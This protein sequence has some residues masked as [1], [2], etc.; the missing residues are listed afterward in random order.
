MAKFNT[1][2]VDNNTFPMERRRQSEELLNNNSYLTVLG[3]LWVMT[4]I[5]SYSF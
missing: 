2:G 5:I 1:E 3:L 4:D